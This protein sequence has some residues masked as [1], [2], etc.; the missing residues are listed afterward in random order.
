[1]KRTPKQVRQLTA[2][3]P[4]DLPLV[5]EFF[6]FAYSDKGANDPLVVLLELEQIGDLVVKVITVNGRKTVEFSHTD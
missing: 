5:P 6:D 1:V 2:P 4:T 3:E